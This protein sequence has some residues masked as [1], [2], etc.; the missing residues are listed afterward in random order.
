MNQPVHQPESL[1]KHR[2]E[3][4][5][6][7]QPESLLKHRPENLLKHQPESLLKHRPESLLKHQLERL[8]CRLLLQ[9]HFL[10]QKTMTLKSQRA[11]I[12]E[13]IRTVHYAQQQVVPDTVTHCG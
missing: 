2:P 7:H 5:L 8:L 13:R 11:F 1:L 3:S 4:L 9:N 6:K 10:V 12:T